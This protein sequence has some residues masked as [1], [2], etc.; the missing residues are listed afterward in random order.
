LL[1]ISMEN[2][3]RIGPFYWP[4]MSIGSEFINS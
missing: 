1:E 3:I 4:L 2:T